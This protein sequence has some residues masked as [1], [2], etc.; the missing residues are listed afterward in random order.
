MDAS[1]DTCPLRRYRTKNR[2]LLAMTPSSAAANGRI[3]RTKFCA[4]VAD[5]EADD[6]DEADADGD[7]DRSAFAPLASVPESTLSISMP[8]PPRRYRCHG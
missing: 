8:L 3:S 6:D 4:M 1:S 5:D 7:A 2:R